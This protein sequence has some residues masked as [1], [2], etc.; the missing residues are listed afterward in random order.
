MWW[1][2]RPS[3]RMKNGTLVLPLLKLR[4]TV[5]L[6][7]WSN[8]AIQQPILRTLNSDTK[9]DLLHPWTR[10]RT[11]VRVIRIV[12]L[13]PIIVR[14]VIVVCYKWVRHRPEVGNFWMILNTFVDHHCPWI[15]NCVGKYNYRYFVAF[16]FW[17]HLGA[18]YNCLLMYSTVMTVVRNSRH[19]PEDVQVH[20]TFFQ[21]VFSY[22]MMILWSFMNSLSVGLSVGILFGW[23]A[24]LISSAQVRYSVD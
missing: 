5:L 10:W 1:C 17:L 14:F 6:Y 19:S 7:R 15:N 20:L 22:R 13:E 11:V 4:T 23:H 16:L 21:T 2:P 18:V 3:V 24:Y 9:Q 12:P 8:N